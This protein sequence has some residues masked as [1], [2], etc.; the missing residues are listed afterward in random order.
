MATK[1]AAAGAT[2]DCDAKYLA[3]MGDCLEEIA[4][5]RQAMKRTDA[6]IRRLETSTH[7]KLVH[8]RANLHVEEAA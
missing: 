4:A 7:R 6:E 8:L 3:A 5:I 2:L 1:S